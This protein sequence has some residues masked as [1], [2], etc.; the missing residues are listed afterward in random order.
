MADGRDADGARALELYRGALERALSNDDHAQAFYH[1]INAAFMTWAYGQDQAAARS[2]AGTALDHA[3]QAPDALWS[4]AT[5]GEALLYSGD[6]AAA[7]AA[8]SRA[9][10][11]GHTP[12]EVQSMYQQA[13][14]ASQLVGDADLIA[15][16]DALFLNQP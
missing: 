13:A 6:G 8:Y 15:S 10:K 1:A 4:A 7:V 11:N 14:W 5:E 12:R 3:R 16:V 2:L 9:L